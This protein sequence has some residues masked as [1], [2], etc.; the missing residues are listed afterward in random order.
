MFDINAN[1]YDERFGAFSKPVR[2]GER[3]DLGTVEIDDL[4]NS[5]NPK[6]N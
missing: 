3:V 5:G 6:S 4:R 2:A 1:P